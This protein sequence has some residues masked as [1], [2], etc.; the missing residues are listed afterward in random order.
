[1]PRKNAINELGFVRL[2][3]RRKSP[4]FQQL[5]D[6][7]RTAI[8]DGSLSSNSRI[9]SSRDLV[10]QLGVSRTTVVSA[11]DRLIAEGYLQTIVGSGTFVSSDI[12]N[13]CPFVNTAP[14]QPDA[15]SATSVA[16]LSSYV[17]KY[18][19]AHQ[20]IGTL[21]G[22]SGATRPFLPG[23]PALDEFPISVWSQIVR[24][25]WKSVSGASL[26]YG[27][28]PGYYPLRDSIAEYLRAHR[29][30]RCTAEQV[31]IVNGTQ[32][33]VDAIARICLNPG[34]QVLFENPGYSFA[35]R[36]LETNG[37]TVAPMRVD[38]NGA[39]VEEALQQYPKARMAYVTPSHQYPLGVTLTIE[40]RLELIK[41]AGK[42]NSLIVE[43]DYDSEF[44]YSQK[45]IPSLQGL[46][47]SQRT[48]YIGSFSKVVFPA[49]SLG[50]VIVPRP[51]VK[52][53]ENA[54][55]LISRP[56]SLVDQRVLNTFIRDGHFARHLR[57]MRKTHALRRETFVGSVETHLSDR[58]Q[59]IGSQ[60]GLHCAAV[61]KTG[62]SDQAA[63]KKLEANG[64]ISRS[65]SNYYMPT[66][67]E[68]DRVGG[69]IFGFACATPKQIVSAIKKTADVL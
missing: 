37:A 27:E 16:P 36:A 34:D 60:A 24:R 47:L 68:S 5:Y 62:Q 18:G 50:Y 8:L 66:T 4:L 56:A 13:D 3:G 57:R 48:V 51:M 49:L 25:T 11:I 2:D 64:I 67:K 38:E 31:M 22:Y 14:V 7:I 6:S 35:R 21:P 29:G 43:D 58:L 39:M 20:E 40:R 46:D 28:A 9:P 32:Q 41:W 59:I 12:P 55:H 61:L 1:M 65:L 15:V 45:P 69:L 19:A 52:V 17:S 10:N 53:F 54:L 23:V 30:V 33:A 26:S 44:R 63:S 42:T